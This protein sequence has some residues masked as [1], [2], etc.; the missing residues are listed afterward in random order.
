MTQQN[1]PDT[2]RSYR[3]A[4]KARKLDKN[5]VSVQHQLRM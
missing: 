5:N 4:L 2:G 1:W 3:E